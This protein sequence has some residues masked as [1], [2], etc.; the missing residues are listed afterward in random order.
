MTTLYVF[1]GGPRDGETIRSDTEPIS[2]WS[3][4]Q[5]RYH[6][7]KPPQMTTMG[8]DVAVVLRFVPRT[9]GNTQ[10]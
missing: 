8:T 4:L 6:V 5:G 2:S 1:V 10:Q 7:D 3:M 9:P